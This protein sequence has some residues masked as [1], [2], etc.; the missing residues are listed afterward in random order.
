MSE[1]PKEEILEVLKL[2]MIGHLALAV[3]NMP[4]VVPICYSYMNGK[5]YFNLSTPGKKIDVLKENPKICFV[6]DEWEE[7]GSWRSVIIDGT[8]KLF[9]DPELSWKILEN[10]VGT[11]SLEAFIDMKE[12][13]ISLEILSQMEFLVCAVDIEEI[14]GRSSKTL[15]E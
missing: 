2:N 8:A 4:Y 9:K 14:T 5:L 10:F 15:L 12:E 7:D 6:V 13:D 3:N 1:M 11:L